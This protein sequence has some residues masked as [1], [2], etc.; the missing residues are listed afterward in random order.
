MAYGGVLAIS[1]LFLVRVARIGTAEVGLLIAAGDVGGVLGALVA[2]RIAAAIGTARTLVL[3][4]FAGG[5]ASLL[6]PLTGSG[7]RAVFF[8]VGSGI[9]TGAIVGG[10]IVLVS[11]R[12][13]YTPSDVLG[14]TTASQRFLTFG[15]APLG[16]LLAGALSI[17]FG[18][19]DALWVLVVIFALSATILLNRVILRDRDLP[20]APPPK[21]P[22]PK[23][24]PAVSGP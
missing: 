2:R 17:A 9:V 18:I 19:R 15:S 20:K 3:S 11:F 22:P 21:A 4:A 8:V 6:L 7:W 13:T 16:A 24:Q 10:S 23:A 14:R 1:V 12:Q 5:L